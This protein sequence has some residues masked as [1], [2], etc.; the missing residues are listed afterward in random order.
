MTTTRKNES[1]GK[2]IIDARTRN[3]LQKAGVGSPAIL[4]CTA[5]SPGRC[6]IYVMYKGQRVPAYEITGIKVPKAY[7]SPLPAGTS[8][9]IDEFGND[10]LLVCVL[11]SRGVM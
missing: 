10:D 5:G 9:R 11:P 1:D 6:T 8:C 3:P 2:M 4:S 7:E